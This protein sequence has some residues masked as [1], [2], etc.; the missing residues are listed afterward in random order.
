MLLPGVVPRLRTFATSGF[1]WLATLMAITYYSFRL[2]PA[3]H[4]YLN[5]ANKGR[6]GVRHVVTEAYRHLVF[7]KENIDQVIIFSALSLGFLL[8]VM[9]FF[10][11]LLMFLF[12]PAMA[13]AIDY[14]GLFATANP[15]YDIAFMLLDSVFGIPDLYG[16]CVAQGIPCGPTSPQT[17]PP[18][19]SPF[20]DGLHVLFFF[21]SLALLVV[22]VLILLY[23]VLIMVGE[24]A[25]SGTPFGRRFD[26]IWAPIRLVVAIGLLV[27]I[28]YGLGSGQYITLFAAKLGSGFATNG[29][30]LYNRSL[31]DAIGWSALNGGGSGEYLIARPSTPT[32]SDVMQFM[33]LVR[34]CKVAYETLY[35]DKRGIEIKPFLVKNPPPP[36]EVTG[37]NAPPWQ[38]AVDFYNKGDIVI[39][40]GHDGN[41]AGGGGPPMYPG[42]RG[43]VEPYCGEV[44]IHT[45]D[46]SFVGTQT[47]QAGYYA[48]IMEMWLDD[49]YDDYAIR[50]N[51]VQL[52]PKPYA[53]AVGKDCDGVDFGA[54]DDPT[55]LP[56]NAWKTERAATEWDRVNTFID[57]AYLDMVAQTD[58]AVSQDILDRGWGGAGIW[59]NKIAQWN[60]AF[61][62]SVKAVPTASLMPRVMEKIQNARRG[63]D[64]NT[65]A[66]DRF[67]PYLNE[68]R[69]VDFDIDGEEK[70]ATVLSDVYKDWRTSKPTERVEQQTQGNV[71][72]DTLHFMFGLDGLYQMRDNDPVHPLAQLV[73][74]GKSIIDGAIH[75]L[76]I[77]LAFAAG[78]GMTEMMEKHV[79]A[80]LNA[81]S[82][83]FV[84]LTTI[85]LSIGFV[86][87][88][89]LPF[90]P[91][92]YFYFAVGAWVKTIFEAMV[93]VPLWALAHLRV[94]GTGLPGDTAMNGYFLIFEIFVRPILT[95][96]GLLAAMAI[97]SAMARTMHG[98]F[99][100]VTQNLT[101][102]D[103]RNC[104][105]GINI[106]GSLEFKRSVVDEFFFTL[107]Y[108]ILVWIMATSSFK[109]IDQIPNGILRWMGAGVPS[110]GDN[111]G[112]PADGLIQYAAFGGASV[113]QQVVGAL[114]TGARTAGNVPGALGNLV[115]NFKIPE[116]F[117]IKGSK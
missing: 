20:H 84:S 82:G 77:S 40:F 102:F 69:S 2:L 117:T 50:A 33:T 107:V 51:C 29:W 15:D 85:G 54:G 109:L 80:A 30:L 18:F 75:N 4:P 65:N 42:A 44:T 111:A 64:Q 97:F 17:P 43:G 73:A 87:Y 76:I 112:D 98:L 83:I 115:G 57:Q 41:D 21:Y 47:A 36:T 32:V 79:G 88:Y 8:L 58:F 10:Y 71:I 1:S 90:M 101:G 22:G 3:H 11:I 46:Q 59:Y 92:I 48:W 37:P 96:F 49:A 100:L 105:P 28:N 45:K 81:M 106:A 55:K 27:P 99:P 68:S 9:Q 38:D 78:G 60:G 26:H 23:Y 53:A 25:Q 7:K 113:S 108:T 31:E 62:A 110:F 61:F 34:T 19:P 63:A 95:V 91:F 16:S 12:R 13:Q 24:T 70:I 67:E 103:C 93:G 14:F 5:P 94:D 66:E 6:F 39:R 72:F 89:V 114:Q 104:D 56:P 35:K 52:T 74:I 116:Q 86:L